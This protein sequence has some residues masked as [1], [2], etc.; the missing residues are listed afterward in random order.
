MNTLDKT[1][2]KTKIIWLSIWLAGAIF[3][4]LLGLYGFTSHNI[5]PGIG[6]KIFTWFAW[7]VISIPFIIKDFAGI[8]NQST[9]DSR[10]KG[11]HQYTIHSNGSVSNNAF[12]G[13]IFGFVIGVVIGL[14][15]GPIILPI[16]AVKK[17]QELV[18][19]IKYLKACKE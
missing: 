6:G 13:A 19:N 8:V 7:G 2:I 17:I 16:N 1:K 3:F 5:A 10:R 12:K 9:K 15:F 11:A 4:W 18:E 14:L